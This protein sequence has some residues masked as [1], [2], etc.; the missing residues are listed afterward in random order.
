MRLPEQSTR[1]RASHLEVGVL[2]DLAA[3]EAHHL[4]DGGQVHIRVVHQEQADA[5]AHLDTLLA[6]VVVKL[7]LRRCGQ[8]ESRGEEVREQGREE[9]RAGRGGY[10]AGREQGRAGKR[11]LERGRRDMAGFVIRWST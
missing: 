11:R 6:Q 2:E 1:R 7:R 5:A 8:G 4:P 3:R 9:G 10:R